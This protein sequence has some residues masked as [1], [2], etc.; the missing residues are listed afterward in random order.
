MISAATIGITA[1]HFQGVSFV[2]VVLNI[3][4]VPVFSILM[5]VSFFYFSLLFLLL[6][7]LVKN[8]RTFNQK[9]KTLK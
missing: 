3:I 7:Y 1:W 2:S 4:V 5:G 8:T 9:W 6:V